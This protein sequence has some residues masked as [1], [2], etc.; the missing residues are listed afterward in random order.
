MRQ[1]QWHTA[2]RRPSHCGTTPSATRLL[3]DV[4]KL[5]KQ[6]NVETGPFLFDIDFEPALRKWLYVDSAGPFRV[7]L[8]G[9][10]ENHG[11]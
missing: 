5:A 3:P 9:A 10:K 1:L 8:F 7:A 2:S 11:N 4:T 6:G